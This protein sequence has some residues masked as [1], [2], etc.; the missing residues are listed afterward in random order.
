MSF[1]T[2]AVNILENL[3]GKQLT[4]EQMANAAK[5]F[6]NYRESDNLTN[7]EIAEQFVIQLRDG[8]RKLRIQR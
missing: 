6:I 1:V 4:N 5:N 2:R 7:A 3:A 8:V